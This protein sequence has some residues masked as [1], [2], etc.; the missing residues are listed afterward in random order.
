MTRILT[1]K[2]TRTLIWALLLV[3][4]GSL[5]YLSVLRKRAAEV[6][7]LAVEI[8]SGENGVLIQEKEVK[9]L[10]VKIV[11]FKPER[12]AIRKI[13]SMKLERSLE[14]DPRIKNAEVYFDSKNRLHVMVEPK[15]VILRVSDASGHQYFLD[16]SGQQ[17]PVMRGG[18][19]RV[20]LANGNIES[21]TKGFAEKA[22]SSSLKEVFLLV[23]YIN[24][25]PFLKA[26][27]EQLYVEES[28]DITF[29]PKVGKEKLVFGSSVQMEEKF[30]N[31]KIFYRDGLTKLG[32]NRYPILNLKYINQ[33]VLVDGKPTPVKYGRETA[34]NT[35][36]H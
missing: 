13:N 5:L 8:K 18:A 35:V 1:N 32:W 3:G 25:D 36:T 27:I 4:I 34:L 6:S 28:G 12:K 21:Y 16:A 23:K 2:V 33:V 30:D 9:K 14:E 7:T 26:L 10:V 29:I 17:V 31:L 19:V 11:G 20:P 24:K 22:G 15:E